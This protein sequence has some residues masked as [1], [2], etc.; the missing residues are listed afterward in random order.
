MIQIARMQL[1]QGFTSLN[2]FPNLFTQ[3]DANPQMN[4][5][6]LHRATRTSQFSRFCNLE[7]IN[8]RNIAR[9]RRRQEQN[10]AWLR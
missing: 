3:Q 2:G 10:A 1:R 9:F 6:I 8:I 4:R 7:R 5:L